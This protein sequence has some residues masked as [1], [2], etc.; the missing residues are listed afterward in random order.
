MQFVLC[1]SQML[2]PNLW[3]KSR[4][5][6]MI[7]VKRFRLCS[8]L[9]IPPFCESNSETD[10]LWTGMPSSGGHTV[11]V[12]SLW[13]MGG[14]FSHSTPKEVCVSAGQNYHHEIGA[15]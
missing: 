13:V 7:G 1:K 11:G 9:F 8:V 14:E 4:E 10:A 6:C 12:V 3:A 5:I 15:C 2:D